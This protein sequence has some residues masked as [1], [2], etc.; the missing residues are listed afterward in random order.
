[1]MTSRPGSELA[2][3]DCVLIHPSAPLAEWLERDSEWRTVASAKSAVLF[4]RTS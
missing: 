1:V 2:G 3:V 4:V